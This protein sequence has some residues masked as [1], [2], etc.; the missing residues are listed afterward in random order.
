[1]PA[2]R[3]F[4]NT[5]DYY[6]TLFHELTHAT[7]HESRL[8]RNIQNRFGS[9][10]YAFEELVAELGAAFVMAQ[11]GMTGEHFQHESYLSNWLDKL[12]G[13]KKF[14]F[15]AASMAS[16]AHKLINGETANK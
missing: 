13:D 3:A 5:T 9:K 12:K 10:D 6:S 11:F 2:K 15:Q 4:H 1:M 7:G 14:I 8:N 16:K